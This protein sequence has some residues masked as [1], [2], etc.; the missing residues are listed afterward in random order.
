MRAARWR[1][2]GYLRPVTFGTFLRR[3]APPAHLEG[4]E[5]VTCFEGIEHF[6]DPEAHL[7]EVVRVLKPGGVYLVST[8]HPDANPH[9]EENPY[10]IHEFEPEPER[11]EAM[12]RARFEDVAMFGQRRLQTVAHWTAQRLDVFGLRRS[13]LLRPLAKRISRSALRTASVDEATLDDLAIELFEDAAMEYVAVC[14]EP[15][16]R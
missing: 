5:V 10:H 11:F 14:R 2:I 8:P 9:G 7:G 3:R 1:G 16:S 13:K 12:L 15:T 6:G 4:G